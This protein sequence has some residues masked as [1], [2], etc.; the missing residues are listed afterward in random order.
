MEGVFFFL[1][2][3]KEGI[4][5]CTGMIFSSG[6]QNIFDFRANCRARSRDAT[7]RFHARVSS[8]GKYK[9]G[10][11]C[12]NFAAPRPFPDIEILPGTSVSFVCSN[13]CRVS[14]QK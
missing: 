2:F 5:Y 1:F 10:K 13:G 8:G 3:L 12:E 7:V 11:I 6:P 9:R 4:N 14:M